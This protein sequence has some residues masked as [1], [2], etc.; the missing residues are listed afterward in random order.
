MIADRAEGARVVGDELEL[1][2]AD[3]EPPASLA[4]EGGASE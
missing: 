1:A 2:T 3:L 4:G